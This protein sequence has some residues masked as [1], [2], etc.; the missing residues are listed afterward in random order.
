M[1]RPRSPRSERYVTVWTC[2][3]ARV[4]SSGGLALAARHR[5]QDLHAKLQSLLDDLA[6]TDG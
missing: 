3:V 4:P 6:A 5:D 1:F 2:E